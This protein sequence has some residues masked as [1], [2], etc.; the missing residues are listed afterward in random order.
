[1]IKQFGEI[2]QLSSELLRLGWRRA[3]DALTTIGRVA[4]IADGNGTEAA[5]IGKVMVL[6][7]AAR[8]Y[9]RRFDCSSRAWLVAALYEGG[10]RV[11]GLWLENSGRGWH[12]TRRSVENMARREVEVL[13]DR[14]NA[15]ALQDR[16]VARAWRAALQERTDD[17]RVLLTL[18]LSEYEARAGRAF[19]LE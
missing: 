12:V 3:I 6:E 4:M 2:P 13:T 7:E 17:M 10:R 1:M 16:I 14:I 9:L 19:E 15:L 5:R 8:D 11:D 18:F